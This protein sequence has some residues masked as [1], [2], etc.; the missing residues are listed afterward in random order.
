M[1]WEHLGVNY[2]E[3]ETYPIKRGKHFPNVPR[4]ILCQQLPIGMAPELTQLML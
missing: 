4:D 2:R 1:R 3:K